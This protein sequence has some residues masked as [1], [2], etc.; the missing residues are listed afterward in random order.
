MKTKTLN[1][2]AGEIKE[3]S[4]EVAV[5]QNQ[6]V[7]AII[8]Q[9]VSGNASVETLERLFAL[10]KEVKA[11]AAKEEF[12]QALAK[13]QEECPVIEKKKAV[14]NRDGNT[15]RYKFAPIDSIVEQIKRALAKNGL[16]YRWTVESTDKGITATC[17][18]TH[19]LGHSESSS[20]TIPVEEAK[21]SKAG[22]ELMSAPQRHASALTFAKRY[23]LCN[24]LGIATGDEDDD[25]VS[26]KKESDAKSPKAKIITRLRA[27][28]EKTE[29]REQI[30]EA[31][32][33]LAKLDLVDENFS[34]IVTRLDVVVA[35]RH[36][37]S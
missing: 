26:V 7:E 5:A 24:A 19:K 15:V 21:M 12:V 37:N 35:D 31:V 30:E 25:A 33:R 2:V 13:F 23:S 1:E 34:E 22:F 36:E 27:L 20:F 10:R 11:E 18:I 14:L 28:G 16:S 8:S 3:R 17:I 9:A 4:T 29:T 6:S 32:K